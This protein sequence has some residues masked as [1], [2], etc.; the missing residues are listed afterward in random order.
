[1]I[2]SKKSFYFASFRIR[3]SISGANSGLK[4]ALNRGYPYMGKN[5]KTLLLYHV[6]Q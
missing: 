4:E 1:M 3:V 2:D 6:R 5:S